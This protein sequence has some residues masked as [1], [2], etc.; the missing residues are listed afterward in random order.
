[1]FGFGKKKSPIELIREALA[2]SDDV[3]AEKAARAAFADENSTVDT[4]AWAAA[5]MYERKV[6]SGLDLIQTFVERFPGSLHLPRVY[7]AD[8][9]A[10]S[11]RFDAATDH[12]RIYLRCASDAGV[13]EK[14]LQ[15]P[16]LREGVA[17]AFLLVTA[18]Y[19][20]T[21]ARTYAGRVIKR[22]LSFDLDPRWREILQGEEIRLRT[23]LVEPANRQTDEEWES[24]FAS[25]LNAD[26]LYDR[27][28]AGGYP[29]LAKRIDLIE[30]NFRFNAQFKVDEREL[31]LLAF[32]TDRNENLLA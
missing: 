6:G 8:L 18:A 26:S 29:L 7:L 3:A 22:A 30:S 2:K 10:Q 27:C 11:S 14:P 12:A 4:L 17:R 5:V 21:G 28:A 24:F 1:V 16:V 23:E 9:L 15:E 31:L 13:F 32:R 20:E 19:T 25:G